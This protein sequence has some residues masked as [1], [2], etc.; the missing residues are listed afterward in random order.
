MS[1][2]RIQSDAA[3]FFMERGGKRIAELLTRMQ[4]DDID[5][6]HTWVDPELRGGDHAKRLVQALVE[7][8]RSEKRKVLPTCPYIRKVLERSP[9]Y[10]DIRKS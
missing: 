3:G 8:A 1:E 5:A 4:G 10:A 7:R 9:E 2:D 6:H